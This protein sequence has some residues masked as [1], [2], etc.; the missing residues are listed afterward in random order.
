MT[1]STS[2]VGPAIVLSMALVTG[3]WFLQRGVAQ[4]TNVYLQA[5]LFEEV[6]DHVTRQFVDPVD[7]SGLIDSA[8]GG[9]LEDLGD[10][11]TS[12]IDAET[13]ER[14]RFRSGAD[15]DYGGVG[16]EILH[17]EGWV[18]V[19]TP[20]LGGPALRAGIRAGD[21]IVEVEGASTRDWETDQAADVLRGSPG[22]DVS[23][24]IERPGVDEPIPFTLTRAV[25]ELL[26]VPFATMLDEGIGYVPLQIFSETSGREV[27]EAIATL[28]AQGM[29]SLVLDLRN[30]PGGLLDEGIAVADLF[31]E[32]GSLILE[33]RGRAAGQNERFQAGS[34]ELAPELPVVIL[35][36]ENSASASEIVAGA[37]Q[38]HD[39]ALVIGGR[40][41]GKG[42]VQTL[43]RLSG[44]NVLRL[45]T[46]RWYTPMGRSINIDRDESTPGPTAENS[47]LA[48]W[49]QRVVKNDLDDRPTVMS[50]GGRTLRGGGGITPD[51]IVLPDTLSSREQNAVQRLFRSAG[52]FS[53]ALFNHAV[54]YVQDHPDLESGFDLP[55]ADLD[56]F[57]RFLVDENEVTLTPEDFATAVRF[58]THQLEREIALQAWG[59]EGA[60]R[61]IRSTDT[62][63][64]RAI[65]LLERAD[66]PEAVF[67]VAA[68]LVPEEK[69]PTVVGASS[70]GATGAN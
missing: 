70:A 12:F 25:I 28:R 20:L 17:Q 10:P 57:Y 44:G 3:G 48:L 14:F 7:R 55:A 56:R 4:E 36:N 62:Q 51:L 61:Q 6:L 41:F 47:T 52:A 66:T 2:V 8:I 13:W 53:T 58:M 22:T 50:I 40:S 1:K 35:L 23:I 32:D 38:D 69:G 9:V 16:L 54:A 15:A 29:R 60:F 24:V 64:S 43:F 67:R 33:T 39:R 27:R 19:I 11:H 18:T 26:S 49:G 30:N 45:T 65:E 68:D 5:R 42:S 31:L 21:R 63:L 59:D 34:G 37:L 46:A